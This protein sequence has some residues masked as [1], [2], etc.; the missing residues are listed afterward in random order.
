VTAPP[1]ADARGTEPEPGAS[2]PAGAGP[3]TDYETYL[4]IGDLLELQVPL[5]PGAHDELLF[6]VIHQVYELWF[7]LLLHELGLARDELLAGRAFAAVKPLRRVHE[8]ETLLLGQLSVLATMSPDDFLTFRDPLAPA[9]GFQSSQFREIEA[10]GGALDAAHADA[11][12]FSDASRQRLRARLAQPTLWDAFCSCLGA[13]G[14]PMPAGAEGRARRLGSLA[15]VYRDRN[16]SAGH[17][18]LHEVA[19][20]LVD[21]DEAIAVWRFRHAAVA[22][23][24]IGHRPGTGGSPGVAYLR[25]TVGRR[26]FPELWEVRSGAL[27]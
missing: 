20:L 27:T 2:P 4:R 7:K 26:F 19:E 15:A 24:E 21:H 12:L 3:H 16:T 14:L 5:T 6:I 8:I 25:T 18:A 23:R 1:A 22:E 10:L 13:S 17:A 9:S 11:P